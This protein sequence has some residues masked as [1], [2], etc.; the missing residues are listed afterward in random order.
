MTNPSDELFLIAIVDMAPG[1]AEAGQQYED[2]VLD[3]LDRHGGS[4][5]RRMYATDAAAEVHLIRFASRAGY[6]SFMV[7]PDRIALREKLGEA[8][9]T[10]RVVE[11]RGF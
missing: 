1:H 7:D 3:L 9:P 4:V 6:Q 5:E 11:V 8:A 10:T 2:T